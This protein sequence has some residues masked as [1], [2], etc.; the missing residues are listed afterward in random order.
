MTKPATKPAETTAAQPP[1]GGSLPSP[2]TLPPPTEAQRQRVERA[3]RRVT[4]RGERFGASFLP[5][6]GVLGLAADHTDQQGWVTHL[7]DTCGTSSEKFA[8][9]LIADLEQAIRQ[10]G[11]GAIA[12]TRLGA[13]MAAMDG[14]APENE[15]EAM[16]AVQMIGTH[17]LA[18]EMLSRARQSP[19]VETTTA[20][21]GMATKLTRTFTAQT[22]ALAKIRRGG[23]QKVV[24]EHVHIHEGAQA[25]VGAVTYA[26]GRGD[27]GNQER[28]H[29]P[30]APA[31]VFAPSV[32][33]WGSESA[34]ETMPVTSDARPEPVPIARRR[35]G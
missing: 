12:T 4:E 11:A 21:T 18:M 9:N 22:E 35:T 23:A 26:G 17:E 15:L 3:K 29:E 30:D 27:A 32:P 28:P 8:V 33:V 10:R 14:I 2:A 6:G 31:L 1:A 24:V 19:M 5:N 34:R 7:V 20:Y 16:L 13:V 25:V